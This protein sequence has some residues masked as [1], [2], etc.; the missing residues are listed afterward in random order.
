MEGRSAEDCVMLLEELIQSNRKL[1]AENEK[2]RWEHE[3]ARRNQTQVLQRIEQRLNEREAPGERHRSRRRAAA[4]TIAFPVACR[5]SIKRNVHLNDAKTICYKKLHE[6]YTLQNWND[7]SRWT[8]RMRRKIGLNG[9]GAQILH[10]LLSFGQIHD[11]R[12]TLGWIGHFYFILLISLF[13]K[14]TCTVLIHKEEICV[15]RL[16]KI[17]FVFSTSA[18]TKNVCM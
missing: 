3:A 6:N 11:T 15:T 13:E 7:W 17:S 10:K 14:K 8:C 4:H 1:A 2:L 18:A 9:F 12:D 5:V 16:R